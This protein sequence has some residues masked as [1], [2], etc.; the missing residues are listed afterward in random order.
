MVRVLDWDSGDKGANLSIDSL[1]NFGTVTFLHFD[2]PHRV[3]LMM[4]E[5]R[6]EKVN[7]VELITGKVE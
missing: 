2:L 4:K 7:R 1:G 5:G 3:V 6:R